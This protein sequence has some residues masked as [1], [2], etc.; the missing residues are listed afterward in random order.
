MR[1]DGRVYQRGNRWW[2]E[3]WHRGHQYREAA[4]TTEKAA[5]KRLKERMK[6]IAG[7]RFIGPQEERVEVSELLDALER[8]LQTKGAR[9]MASL[10]SHLKPVRDSL[11][12]KLAVDLRTADV[13][14]YIAERLSA[15]KAPATVNREAR[16]SQA[17]FSLGAEAGEAN[18]Y[19]TLPPATRGQ[20]PPG[21]LRPAR[22]RGCNRSP[23]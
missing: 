16:S 10:R 22:G 18:A 9:A 6:Q 8:H 21:I 19:S 13:E 2:V 11:G 5:G 3:Y 1:G 7:D 12:S 4:G 15:E 23:S 17:G 14:R 20:C